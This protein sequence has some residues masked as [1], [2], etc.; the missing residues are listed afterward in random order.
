MIQPV[1]IFF[2]SLYCYQKRKRSG[3][4]ASTLICVIIKTLNSGNAFSP[5]V[6]KKLLASKRNKGFPNSVC[7]ITF[8]QLQLF[9]ASYLH[10]TQ[11]ATKS[12]CSDTFPPLFFAIWNWQ[13]LVIILKLICFIYFVIGCHIKVWMK[14]VVKF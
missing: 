11:F 2:Q 5:S 9:L 4:H 12:L 6:W 3:Y 7:T 1:I 14:Y 10:N 13:Q 8:L